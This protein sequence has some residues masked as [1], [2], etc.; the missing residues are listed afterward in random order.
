MDLGTCKHAIFRCRRGVSS[1]SRVA[2]RRHPPRCVDRDVSVHAITEDRHDERQR[3]S[4]TSW[5]EAWMPAKKTQRQASSLGPAAVAACCEAANNVA[6][7][8]T[9]RCLGQRRQVRPWPWRPR[10]W[11]RSGGKRVAPGNRFE[12]CPLVPDATGLPSRLVRGSSGTNR[13]VDRQCQNRVVKG[14]VSRSKTAFRR[15][16]G[17]IAR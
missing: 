12:S 5:R 6:P 14:R 7:V 11:A 3:Q 15:V 16:L 10:A 1:C 9:S 2:T 4:V 8:P 13:G 17:T